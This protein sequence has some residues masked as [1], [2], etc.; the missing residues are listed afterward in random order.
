MQSAFR[1]IIDLVVTVV[2]RSARTNLLF[3]FRGGRQLVELLDT[4]YGAADSL[5]SIWTTWPDIA[6]SSAPTAIIG[7]IPMS[8]AGSS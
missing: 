8:H 7:M 5:A 4:T 3:M 1:P 2:T 6:Q